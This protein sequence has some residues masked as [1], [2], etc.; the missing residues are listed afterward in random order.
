MAPLSRGGLEPG[1]V[2]IKATEDGVLSGERT[3]E[4]DLEKGVHC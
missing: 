1:E 3:F 2:Q 4:R